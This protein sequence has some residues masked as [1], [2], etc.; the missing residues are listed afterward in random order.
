MIL[1]HNYLDII[2][3]FFCLYLLPIFDI[4]EEK[5]KGFQCFDGSWIPINKF[6]DGHRDCSGK[7]WE[8]EPLECCKLKLNHNGKCMQKFL[9]IEIQDCIQTCFSFLSKEISKTQLQLENIVISLT[10]INFKIYIDAVI[11]T[12]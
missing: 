3:I 2:R 9:Y 6:C 5:N 10:I 12:Q 8:D 7:N 11:K 1:N 4:T